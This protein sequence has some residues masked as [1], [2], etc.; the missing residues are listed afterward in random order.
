MISLAIIFILLMVATLNN[1]A[2]SGE[3]TIKELKRQVV[4]ELR[5]MGLTLEDDPDDPNTAIIRLDEEKVKF[6]FNKANLT[7]GGANLISELFV[8]LAPKLCEKEFV[9]KIESVIV[10]G[11]TDSF[12]NKSTEGKL[13]NVKLSQDRAFAVMKRAFL[14]LDE[15]GMRNEEENLMLLASAIGRGSSKPLKDKPDAASR[16]VEIK[17][18]VKAITAKTD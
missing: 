9:G 1:A 15:K 16:R 7:E 11:H 5:T 6:E 14:S 8:K 10:E 17:I 18:R 2:S 4:E 13:E 3:Q 12:G